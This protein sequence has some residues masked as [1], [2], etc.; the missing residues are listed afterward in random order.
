MDVNGDNSLSR[1]EI[2]LCCKQSNLPSE[3]IDEFLSLFDSDGDSKVTLDEYERALGLKPIPP[4]TT[5]Q[6]HEAFDEM[7]TDKSGKLTVDEM[8][9]G[10][11][12][13]GCAM[14]KS[15]VENIIKS[16]DKDGDKSLT[17]QEFITLMRL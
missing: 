12:N 14:K 17:F 2:R 16:V 10:L 13:A 15:E 1:D 9:E 7:D 4:T 8:Y 11:K 3:K 5:Q 6:W